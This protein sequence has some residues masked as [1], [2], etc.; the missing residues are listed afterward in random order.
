[1]SNPFV[2]LSVLRVLRILHALQIDCF[3]KNF[4]KCRLAY[5]INISIL[6]RPRPICRPPSVG[7]AQ[8]NCSVVW[9][10]SL[11]KTQC[12]VLEQPR[13]IVLLFGTTVFP[14]PS[15]NVSKKISKTQIQAWAAHLVRK[16]ASIADPDRTNGRAIATVLRPSSSTVRHR[17]KVTIDCI[18][19]Q[20]V[21]EI[22]W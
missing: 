1:M 14:R 11:S 9:H 6:S 8:A 16:T 10:Y 2:C 7:V 12:P 17:A 4:E 22:D 5:T 19:L 20:E 18:C 13:L 21:V 3:K 15:A